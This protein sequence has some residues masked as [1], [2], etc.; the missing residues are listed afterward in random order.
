MKP[1]IQKQISLAAFTLIELLV[2]ISIIGVLSGFIIGGLKAAKTFQYK[3][4]VTAELK[5]IENAIESYKTKYGSYPPDNQHPIIA[6]SPGYDP[7][8]YNQLYYELSGVTLAGG[9]Y[10]TLDGA[11]TITAVDYNTAFGVGGIVNVTQGGGEDKIAAKNFLVNL[12]SKQINT[13]ISNK[14]IAN[15]T[16]L[17]TSVR[18]PD[19]SY[20][21]FGVPDVNPFHYNSSHP[22]NNPN[23]YD[24]W[25][26]LVINGKTNRFSNW[27]AR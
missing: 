22:T 9:S 25:V 1:K 3:K 19:I 21:P 16:V 2:V 20:Q 8:I 26:D 10:T 6:G 23:S 14:A 5:F 27:T 4:T 11:A 24:L 18:G 12:S 7:Y 13:Y 17:I 15:T